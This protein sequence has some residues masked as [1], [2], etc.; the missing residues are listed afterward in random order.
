MTGKSREKFVE[1]AEKRVNRAV[2]DIYARRLRSDGIPC[3]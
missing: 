2:K 3:S 1:L